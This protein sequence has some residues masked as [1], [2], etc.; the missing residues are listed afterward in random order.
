MLFSIRLDGLF[1][2]SGTKGSDRIQSSS[3]GVKHATAP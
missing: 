2:V 1:L 3:K